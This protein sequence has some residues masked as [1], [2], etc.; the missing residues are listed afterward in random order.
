MKLVKLIVA[1]FMLLFA[2]FGVLGVISFNAVV[3][4]V[5]ICAAFVTYIDAKRLAAENR[6]NE[7]RS[8]MNVVVFMVALAMFWFFIKII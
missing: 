7:A 2:V 4:V 8:M 1:V 3:P 6:E 5:V